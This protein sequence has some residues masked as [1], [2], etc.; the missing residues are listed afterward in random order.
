MEILSYEFMRTALIIGIVLAVVIPCIGQIIVI[1][2]LSL[3]G[4]SLA[5]VSL[6]GVAAG[7]VLGANPVLGAVLASIIGAFSIEAIRKR[8]PRYSE[9]SIAVM[10]AFGVGLAGVLSSYVPN[11]ANLTAFLFGSVVAIS[12]MEF[13]LVIGLSVVVLAFFAL[14]WRELQAIAFDERLAKLS[15][16]SVDL[17]NIIFTFMT[18]I[19]VAAASRTVGA[20]IVSAILVLPIITAMQISR[21]YT[22]NLLIAIVIAVISMLTA[23]LASFYVGV[24]PG[25]ATALI[26]VF[27]LVVVFAF[28]GIQRR[29][30]K[31]PKRSHQHEGTCDCKYPPVD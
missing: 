13:K 29:T 10:T 14:M 28:K 25:G 26:L 8:L 3:L 1:R 5:H 7:L 11:N 15:G 27:V 9:V 12:D 30:R 23:L 21:G 31:G 6:G 2:H 18:A 22:R 17:V 4:D 24:K 19:V 16:V 20:L